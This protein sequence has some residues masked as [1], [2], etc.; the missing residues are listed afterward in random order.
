MP[1]RV[2]VNGA[3]GRMGLMTVKALSEDPRFDV[4]G[5]TGREYNLKK[6][7]YDSKAD[8]V[9]DFTTPEA[10]LENTTTILETGV[11]PVIGTSGLTT[12]QIKTLQERAQQ[13]QLGGIIAP[14]FSLGAVLMLKYAKEIAKYMP[15]VEII[16]MHHEKKLD[17]PSGTALRSA[18]ILG[19]VIQHQN[20]L[21]SKSLETVK[22]ARGATH[23]GIPI[24]AIRLPGFLAHQEIIFGNIGE[25][26][27]LR[28]DSIDRLCF[29]P[30][31]CFAC[32]KVL[33]LR[34]LVYGLEELL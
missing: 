9:V 28:H 21:P 8:V 27:T 2:L 34:R 32:E 1:I 16:E 31:V 7:I 20:D 17:S 18:E 25:T 24:H 23:H 29:M 19:S 22:G 26:L 15:H 11:H 14:N 13:L 30:G 5:Q 33:S 4:V 3:F 6:S 10:V 12:E